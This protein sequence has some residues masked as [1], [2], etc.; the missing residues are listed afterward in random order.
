MHCAENYCV[1]VLLSYIVSKLLCYCIV[2]S[3]CVVV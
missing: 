1:I 3:Y 2:Q